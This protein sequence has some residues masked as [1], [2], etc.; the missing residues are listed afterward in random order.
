MRLASYSV[1]VVMQFHTLGARYLVR[2]RVLVCAAVA[3]V[4][5]VGPGLAADLTRLELLGTWERAGVSV[6]AWLTFE[7]DGRVASDI[8]FI[9]GLGP[10]MNEGFRS[11]GEYSQV[12]SRLIL[13]GSVWEGWP[14]EASRVVCTA[15]VSADTMELSHCQGFEP[16]RGSAIALPDGVWRRVEQAPW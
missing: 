6:I 7:P 2:L 3:T 4:I 1:S 5:A 8:L 16:D 9:G 13:E 12:G 15:I 10:G 14:F 11:G